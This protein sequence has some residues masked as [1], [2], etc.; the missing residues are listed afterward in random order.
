MTEFIN[1]CFSN[2]E[3]PGN[4]ICTM[5]MCG[6]FSFVLG[7][8]NWWMPWLTG[9]FFMGII[10]PTVMTFVP[11]LLSL[12]ITIVVFF[13]WCALSFRGTFKEKLILYAL[14][15]IVIVIM[16]I[17]TQTF[18]T[19]IGL[20][21]NAGSVPFWLLYTP[22]SAAV[23]FVIGSTWKSITIV[24][25]NIRFMSFFLLPASQLA[26]LWTSVAQLAKINGGIG[27]EQ[28]TTNQMT[29]II[30]F[31]T[32]LVSL[33]ADGVFIRATAKMATDIKERERLMALE[34]ENKMTY[35][36][37]KSMESDIL[38]AKK[39]RHD[40]SNMISVVQRYIDNN[41]ES[42]KESLESM[43]KQMALEV[44]QFSGKHYCDCN[45][46]NCIYAHEEEKMNRLNVTCELYA[47]L[48]EEL[49]VSELDLC[50]IVT[51]LLDN[52]AENSASLSDVHK[53]SVCCN[54]RVYAGY[55]YITVRNTRPSGAIRFES[56]KDDKSLHGLGLSIIRDITLRNNG[57]L[58]VD[59]DDE[60]VTFTATL[61]W[62]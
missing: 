43:L 3:L 24:M 39:Y 29:S 42:S 54:M 40:F 11:E 19:M 61:K 45:I 6:G 26:M 31:F 56:Q 51:N 1:M 30:F 44:K 25:K 48:G 32:F 14:V 27:Y 41:T 20:P 49:K 18:I 47:E 52:A 46:V 59:S 36:Y 7:G 37:I 28:V 21:Y 15:Y 34:T 5:L 2:P 57:E 50:R 23:I 33:I 38:R 10:F 35:D 53:R 60:S 55:L 12:M 13:L 8:R 16:Q 62:D 58:I 22:L 4:I 17:F 9:I